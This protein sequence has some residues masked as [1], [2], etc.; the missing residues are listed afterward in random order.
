MHDIQ[1]R[2]AKE[3]RFMSLTNCFMRSVFGSLRLDTGCM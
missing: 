1:K 2:V 3:F